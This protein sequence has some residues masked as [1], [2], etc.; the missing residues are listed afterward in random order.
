[1]ATENIALRISASD[2]T[3]RGIKSAER[4][5]KRLNSASR[6]STRQMRAHFSQLGYQVQDISV[7][8]QGGQ[9][10]LMVLGQQ[11]S[12]I[13]SVFGMWGSIAGAAVAALAAIVYGMTKDTEAAKS[14]V[15]RYTE[16]LEMLEKV[17]EKTK[18]GQI[19][20][21][22]QIAKTAEVSAA[23]AKVQLEV[24]LREFDKF[25]AAASDRISGL[26][27]D[28]DISAYGLD[29]VFDNLFGNALNATVGLP[30]FNDQL[31]EAA[32]KAGVAAEDLED[33]LVTYRSLF[34]S[35]SPRSFKDFADAAAELALQTQDSGL[36][37]IA[38]EAAKI[39]VE[40]EGAAPG[41]KEV[42]E[43]LSNLQSK[44]DK[45]VSVINSGEIKKELDKAKDE[46]AVFDNVM[47]SSF[48][49]IEKIFAAKTKKINSLWKSVA[50][51]MEAYEIR[52]NEIADLHDE[53]GLP[54]NLRDRLE[55]KAWEDLQ[56]ALEKSEDKYDELFK[57]MRKAS[58]SWGK[59][60]ADELLNAEG[61]FEDFITSV[62]NQIA[63]MALAKTFDPVFDSV[64]N[65]FEQSLPSLIVGGISSS[66]STMIT[67]DG[68]ALDFPQLDTGTNYVP[69]DMV[70]MLHEGEAVVPKAY[71]P[72]VT[73][74][75]SSTGVVVNIIEDSSKAGEVQQRDDGGTQMIDIF[76]DSVKKQI[77]SD[78]MSGRGVIPKTMEGTYGLSR[79]PGGY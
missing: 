14:A 18:D 58:E 79:T 28:T 59:D 15:D 1:M 46:F 20:L 63:R 70:A 48:S 32:N 36:D 67:P 56:G 73:S 31:E 13:A 22:E 39:A 64:G 72:A 29:G 49:E 12:Q 7:Q 77:S 51:P 69:S 71:N 45:R 40:M 10:A 9:N 27:D 17:T 74:V 2:D 65:W 52:L 38:L 37:K 66:P 3:G 43:A 11:G 24:A 5:L 50:T 35:P 30:A 44:L 34:D 54:A 68:F 16:S 57:T 62:L 33:F 55:E 8:L 76:V 53:L 23:A 75:G 47:E 60:L 41:I 21:S 78:I 19:V 42:E 26:F 61:N 6:T 4:N 25:K